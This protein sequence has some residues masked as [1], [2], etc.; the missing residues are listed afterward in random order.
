MELW[1]A[2]CVA[3]CICVLRLI[4]TK[5]ALLFS[6]IGFLPF[7]VA[8]LLGIVSIS[9]VDPA[10]MDQVA[11]K[12]TERIMN[13]GSGLIFDEVVQTYIVGVF[14]GWAVSF[15]KEMRGVVSGF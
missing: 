8:V 7:F 10:T 9:N 3:V 12:A 13:Q 15:T 11:G 1:P 2:I 5:F 6:L 14:F 4:D